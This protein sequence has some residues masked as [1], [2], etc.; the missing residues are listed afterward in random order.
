M[1]FKEIHDR[2]YKAVKYVFRS[3]PEEDALDLTQETFLALYKGMSGFRGQSKLSTWLFAI[4]KH[5]L[6]HWRQ[7][8]RKAAETRTPPSAAQ[9]RVVLEDQEPTVV[10]ERRTP[11]ED[12]ENRDNLKCL[13]EAIE[14]LPKQMQI[15][16]RLRIYDDLSYREIADEMGISIE[17]VKAHL[18]QARKRLQEILG[19]RFGGIDF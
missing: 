9:P 4:A 3:L 13:R 18:F 5:Q 11:Q 2:Y 12:A 15:C 14:S 17:T 16:L 10:D 19:D 7:K 1:D 8:Q 6:Y